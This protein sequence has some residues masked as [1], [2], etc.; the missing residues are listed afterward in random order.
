MVLGACSLKEQG[1]IPKQ[2]CP[3]LSRYLTRVWASAA[4]CCT[5]ASGSVEP[6]LT[7]VRDLTSSTDVLNAA[8]WQPALGGC[9]LY[10]TDTGRTVSLTFTRGIERCLHHVVSCSAVSKGGACGG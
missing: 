10:G 2:Y 7:L 1:A 9:I 4:G 5:G 8:E 6:S 3:T